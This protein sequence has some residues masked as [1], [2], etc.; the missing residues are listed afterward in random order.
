MIHP[1][2]EARLPE[3]K[4]LCEKHHVRSLELFGSATGS[5]F[6]PATSDLDFIVEFLDFEPGLLFATYFDL[7]EGLEKL[8]ERP[9]DLVMADAIRN[10]Y[11][12]ESIGPSRTRLYAA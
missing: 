7:K 12:L 11:F 10:K 9:V 4:P 1:L 3:V 2:V 6:K 5:S 8:F